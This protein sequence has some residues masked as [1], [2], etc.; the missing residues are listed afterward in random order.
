MHEF[1][2][3]QSLMGLV[4]DSAR[5]Q[6]IRQVHQVTVVVGEWSAV[7]PEALTGS[8]EILAQTGDELFRGAELVVVRSAAMGLCG[9]CG[10][11]FE[12]GES[13]LICP[14]CGGSAQL[15]SGNE[16]YVD[17]YEGD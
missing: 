8:F 9:G 13:G 6:G 5:Q 1:S 14:Q 2:L 11:R 3:A 17:S 12:A 10:Q 4:A 16:L 7:L 15:A